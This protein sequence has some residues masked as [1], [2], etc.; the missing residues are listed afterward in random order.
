MGVLSVFT[1]QDPVWLATQKECDEH[2][3]VCVGVCSLW[4]LEM[5]LGWVRAWYLL[6]CRGLGKVAGMGVFVC[7]EVE[8]ETS[9]LDGSEVSF[10]RMSSCVAYFVCALL[11]LRVFGIEVTWV[12]HWVVGGKIAPTITTCISSS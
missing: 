8:N 9:V 11:E 5:V 10:V 2:A 12:E 3:T 6:R 4:Q 1:K 7:R